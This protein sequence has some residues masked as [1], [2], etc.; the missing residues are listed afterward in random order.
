MPGFRRVFESA[1]GALS[2]KGRS[3]FMFFSSCFFGGGGRRGGMGYLGCFIGGF[4]GI[5]YFLGF[6]GS[7]VW[8]KER[9]YLWAINFFFFFEIMKVFAFIGGFTILRFFQFCVRGI[10]RWMREDN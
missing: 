1:L 2:G 9:R 8:D 4:V 6:F 7:G 5:D 3:W 10:V